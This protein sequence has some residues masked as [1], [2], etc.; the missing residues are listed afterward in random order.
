MHE[1]WLRPATA[2]LSA[3]IP[4]YGVRDYADGRVR[5][6]KFVEPSLWRFSRFLGLLRQ[7]VD[8]PQYGFIHPADSFIYEAYCRAAR[9][10]L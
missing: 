2:A 6:D 8:Q 5:I 1:G 9:S 10:D 7:R 3:F 4:T